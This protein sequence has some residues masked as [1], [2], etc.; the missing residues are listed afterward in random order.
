LLGQDRRLLLFL[1]EVDYVFFD[2]CQ[3]AFVHDSPRF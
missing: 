1:E 2:L 3:P